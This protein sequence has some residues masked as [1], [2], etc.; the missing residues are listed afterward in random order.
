MSST[1]SSHPSLHVN[2]QVR[3]LFASD[4]GSFVEWREGSI[5]H[6]RPNMRAAPYKAVDVI[7]F[8]QELESKNWVYAHMQTDTQ[9]SPWELHS[10]PYRPKAAVTKDPTPKALLVGKLLPKA[11]LNHIHT[12]D[13]AEIFKRKLSLSTDA[14]YCQLFPRSEDRLDLGVL[15]TLC[16]Q[17]RYDT[18]EVGIAVLFDDLQRMVANS[19]TLNAANPNFLPFKQ[20]D[21]MEKAI[22]RLKATLADKHGIDSLKEAIKQHKEEAAA[23]AG[24]CGGEDI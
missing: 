9:C 20:A 5:Y 1:G 7:W 4:D 6:I 18:A 24:P 3:K 21:M 12:W 8:D 14:Q 22:S 2:E 11:I 23:A 13:V 10:S 15:N 16:T 19:K 17:G